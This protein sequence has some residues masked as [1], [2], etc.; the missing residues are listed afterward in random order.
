[1]IEALATSPGIVIVDT[2][3]VFGEVLLAVLEASDLVL[4]VVDMDL[5]SVRSAITAL[6][7]LRA[8]AFPL[9]RVRAV[10]NRADSKARLDQDELTRSLGVRVL[11]TIPSDRLLPQS[12]N[13]GEPA[14]FLAERSRPARSFRRM[15]ADMLRL[16]GG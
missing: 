15:A 5:P 11:G 2:P 6:G 7:V 16:L 3:P 4:L 13:E 10:L 12:V 14:V 1:M 8:S 9:E